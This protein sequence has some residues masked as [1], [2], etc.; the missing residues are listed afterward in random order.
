MTVQE[1]AKK[2]MKDA[3]MTQTDVAKKCGTGQSSIGMFLKSKSMRVDSLLA[4]LDACGF[5]L[6]VRNGNGKG[7]EYII[8]GKEGVPDVPVSVDPAMSSAIRAIVAE[9]LEKIAVKKN[10][11]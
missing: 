8:D 6:V 9:E 7:P 4:I 1:V 2:V 11:K 3:N 10:K 5:E